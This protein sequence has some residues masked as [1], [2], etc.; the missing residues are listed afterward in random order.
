MKNRGKKELDRRMEA[1]SASQLKYM[2]EIELERLRD[3]TD[4][5]INLLMGVDGRIFSSSIPDDLSP[6][7]FRLLST[8]KSNLQY[9][10][11]KL[12][13][14]NLEISVERWDIGTGAVA[15]VGNNAFLAS[16][17]TEKSELSDMGELL[18]EIIDST[19]VLRHIF[20][21]KPMTEEAL[22][23]Y[24]D[25][26]K[27]ELNQLSRQLFVERFEH[28]KQYQKNQDILE[29]IEEKIKSTVG[30]GSMEEMISVTFNEMGTSAPY[31]EDDQ[32]PQFIDKIVDGHIRDIVG[33][34]QA[35]QYKKQWK[36][37]LEDK[38]KGY[39]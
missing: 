39:I 8:F 3:R 36:E 11:A 34:I 24:P 22:S 19:K 27:E 26:I 35:E 2:L 10:C 5:D 28:T 30:V 25:K 18:G 9:I 29:F 13:G 17:M 21:E 1:E 15:A 37:E 4:I 23:E 20:E 32:W 6:N 14:E 33:D 31:M 12:K 16:L 38:L 7:Q